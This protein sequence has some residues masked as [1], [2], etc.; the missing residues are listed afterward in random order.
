ME[1]S[2][3]AAQSL[4][5]AHARAMARPLSP[6][7]GRR[8]R[9]EDPPGAACAA[10]AAFTLIELLAVMAIIGVLAAILFGAAAGARERSRR[11]Q[12]AA[13]LAVFAHALEAYRA[14]CGDYP[15]TG[16]AANV[17]TAPAA[18]DD[19][20]GIFFNALAGRRGPAAALTPMARRSFV[21]P[22]AHSVQTT[23]LPDGAE[24]DPLTNAFLDPWGRRYLYWYKTGPAWRVPAPVLVAA[25]A[26]GMITPPAD[27]AAWDGMLAAGGAN[28]DNLDAFALN[29]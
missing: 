29:P 16:P 10:M 17:P 19:G 8:V 13:E 20:P 23:E 6:H 22:G 21:A 2:V 28:A 11:A 3:A 7:D 14:A 5:S 4:N 1:N 24:A 9:N 27:L 25:G 18:A 26:D 12:A 15:R